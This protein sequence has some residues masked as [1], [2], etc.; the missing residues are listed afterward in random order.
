MPRSPRKAGLFRVTPA[1]QERFERLSGEGNDGVV[2]PKAARRPGRKAVKP[3]ASSR[4]AAPPSPTQAS[5]A[6]QQT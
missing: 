6:G 4:D 1:E 2:E 3:P 5:T